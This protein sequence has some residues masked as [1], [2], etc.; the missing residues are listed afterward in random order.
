MTPE[1]QQAIT[2]LRAW[3]RAT[4]NYAWSTGYDIRAWRRDD[5]SHWDAACEAVNATCVRI[6]EQ[7]RYLAAFLDTLEKEGKKG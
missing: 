7:P 3:I 1:Q 2:A 5:C 4:G 6:E